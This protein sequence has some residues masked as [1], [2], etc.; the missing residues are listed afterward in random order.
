VRRAAALLLMSGLGGRALA[1]AT[2]TVAVFPFKDLSSGGGHVGDAIRETVTTDLKDVPGIRVIERSF[3]D[4][5]LAEQDLQ[6]KRADL[7]PTAT[8]RIGKLLGA[9]LVVVGAYQKSFSSVRLTARFVNVETGEIVGTAKVDGAANELFALQDRVTAELLKSAGIAAPHV[10]KFV[11][12]E[13]PKIKSFKA[14]ELYADAV[15]ET[16]DGKKRDLLKMALNEEP[17]FTY[18]ARDLDALEKRMRAYAGIARTEQHKKIETQLADVEKKLREAKDPAEVRD[19]YF[20]LLPSLLM[21][22]HW[23]RL[24]VEARKIVDNP[25]PDP[26]RPGG[27]NISLVEQAAYYLVTAESQLKQRDSVLLDGEA[28]MKRFPTSPYFGSVQ[29]TMRMT[30]EYKRKQDEGKDKAAKELAQLNTRQKWDLCRIALEYRREHQNVE[31]QRLY[32][33]CVQ[34]GT[35][36]RGDALRDLVWADIELGD[37]KAAR[38]DLRAFAQVGER[39]AEQMRETFEQQ[40]PADD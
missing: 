30:I 15:V 17:G 1:A 35:H 11:K 9:S 7:D 14:V 6:A 4:K 28:F 2:P 26:P 40:V 3:I 22:R 10:Q 23:H 20:Q 32:R 13:R 39:G 29:S 5:V 24:A 34:A 12:R 36:E 31:A 18:A 33:A 38:A 8:V 16:D 25:P 19:A 21:T 27:M 37:W